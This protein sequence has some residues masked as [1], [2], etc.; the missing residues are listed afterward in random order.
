MAWNYRK[1]IKIIP[2]VRLNLSKGGISTSIGIRGASL[3]LGKKGAFVNTG[4]PGSGFY[5]RQKISSINKTPTTDITPTQN[6]YDEPTDNIFSADIQEITS[7]DMQGVKEAII[8]ANEQRIEL[9]N[10]LSKIEKSLKA[11][12]F[13][14]IASYI[15]IIGLVKK[16]VSENI[17]TDIEAKKNAINQIVEQIDNC[18]VDLDVDFESEIKT[19]YDNLVSAFKNLCTSEKIWDITNSR[20]EDNRVT[21]SAASTIVNRKEVRFQIKGIEDIKSQS[22]VLCFTNANGVDMYFYP[23]FIVMYN[24]QEKFALIGIDELQ[25]SYTPVRFVERD[26]LSRDTTVVEKTWA[27]VN[28]NGTPDRRFKGNYQIPVVLYGQ[29]KLKTNTGVNEE[30]QFSND[31]FTNQFASS[32]LEFQKLVK[33]LKKISE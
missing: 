18:Y 5:S 28:R 12:K 33:G 32:F 14:L 1:R 15:L 24:T 26:S 30:Y 31:K 7:Q 8:T 16:S 9:K 19:V 27:K 22:E 6:Q 20:F 10:D 3:T 13:K 23:N 17:K 21:R 2:G 25:L 29:I 4:I 11:S